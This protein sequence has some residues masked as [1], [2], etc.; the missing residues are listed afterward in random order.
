MRRRASTDITT[1]ILARSGGLR[2]RIN[3]HCIQCIY[4][5]QVP[6]TWRQQVGECQVKLCALWE[7]RARSSGSKVLIPTLD[8]SVTPIGG[9]ERA[10]SLFVAERIAS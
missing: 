4:D 6:G 5:D 2:A 7:V 1:E 9:E 10:N 3:C 8:H